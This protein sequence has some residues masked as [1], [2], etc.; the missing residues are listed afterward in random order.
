MWQ[1]YWKLF[2]LEKNCFRIFKLTCFTSLWFNLGFQWCI[3]TRCG[4][5]PSDL[6]SIFYLRNESVG[7]EKW[8]NWLPSFISAFSLFNPNF[9]SHLVHFCLNLFQSITINHH[10]SPPLS[11]LLSTLLW[12]PDCD[13]KVSNYYGSDEYNQSTIISGHT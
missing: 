7:L 11:Q 13:C 6:Y 10:Q 12:Y 3:C 1:K 8:Y 9:L 5:L 4:A 2:W